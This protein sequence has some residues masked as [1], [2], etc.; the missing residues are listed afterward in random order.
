MTAG[1]TEAKRKV[2]GRQEA[3]SVR[4]RTQKG[5]PGGRPLLLPGLLVTSPPA[6][7]GEDGIESVGE[8]LPVPW[9]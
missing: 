7:A 4:A 8:G 3:W 5:R 2:L 1:T 9:A 6:V